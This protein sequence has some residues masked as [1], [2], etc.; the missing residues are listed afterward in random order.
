MNEEYSVNDPDNK[1]KRPR[2]N[3]MKFLDRTS[4]GERFSNCGQG[5]ANRRKS[6]EPTVPLTANGF[7]WNPF[8]KGK[9]KNVFS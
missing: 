3:Q 8:G 9:K 4:L 7:N 6:D 5:L 1:K 2:R